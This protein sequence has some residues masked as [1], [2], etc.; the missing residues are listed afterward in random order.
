MR[1]VQLER[2]SFL[3]SQALPGQIMIFLIG[4]SCAAIHVFSSGV[5]VRIKGFVLN[6]EERERWFWMRERYCEVMGFVLF[7]G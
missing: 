6:G 1:A 5:M 7:K 4:L 2:E 3:F